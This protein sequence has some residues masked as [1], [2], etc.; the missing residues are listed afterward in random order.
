VYYVGDPGHPGYALSQ[1]QTTGFGGMISFSLRKAEEVIPTLNHLRLILFAES[2]GGTETLLTFP[3]AQTHGAI[4]EDMRAMVGVNDRLL[5]L[6]A[7]IED[8]ADLIADLDQALRAAKQ[9]AG[10]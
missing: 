2:L 4:P 10:N 3:L 6:S 1:R 7:G 5:R 8:A 9:E